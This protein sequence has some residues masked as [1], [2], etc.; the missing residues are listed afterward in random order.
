[1]RLT[2]VAGTTFTAYSVL[3]SLMLTNNNQTT[4]FSIV[5]ANPASGGPLSINLT[6]TS[7]IT[8]IMITTF[9]LSSAK[10]VDYVFFTSSY[11]LNR[12]TSIATSCSNLFGIPT[13][14][15]PTYDQNCSFGITEIWDDN[16]AVW[17]NT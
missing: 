11:S 6:T 1:M 2:G 4:M 3:S 17:R 9:I 15:G 14:Y 12:T 8:E 10:P 7:S 5:A 16:P 13:M